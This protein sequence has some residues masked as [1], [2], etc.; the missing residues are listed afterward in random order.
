M[1]DQPVSCEA[2]MKYV[3]EA[4]TRAGDSYFSAKRCVE[5]VPVVLR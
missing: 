2:K 1:G 3:P 5:V 4:L